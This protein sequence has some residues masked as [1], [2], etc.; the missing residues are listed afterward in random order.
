MFD[1]N[2]PM[3]PVMEEPLIILEVKF[4]EYLPDMIKYALQAVETR[5]EAYSKYQ[6]SRMFG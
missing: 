2:L 1:R 3:V 5:T 6:L 4:D